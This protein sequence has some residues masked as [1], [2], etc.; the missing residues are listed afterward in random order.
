MKI[1]QLLLDENFEIKSNEVFGKIDAK[2]VFC[3]ADRF[4]LEKLGFLEKI[5]SIY[6]NANVVSCS[7]S[8]NIIDIE[9]IENH[10]VVTAIEFEKS[11]CKLSIINNLDI[12]SSY[13]VGKNLASQ[14]DT[15]NLK[16]VLILSDGQHING[17]NLIK[18]FNDVLPQ[19][20]ST[21]GGLAGDG[22]RFEKTLVGLNNNIAQGNIVAIAFYGENLEIKHSSQGGWDPFGPK[23]KVTKA[24]DNILYELDGKNALELYEIYLGDKAKDLPASGLLFPLSVT[25]DNNTLVRTILNIDND[26][27]SMIFAG[28]IPV[29]AT[30]Q[31]MRSNFDNL[32]DGAANA[33]NNVF[34]QNEKNPDLLFLVSCVGRKLVLG[35]RIEEELE[36]IK[37]IFGENSVLTGFYSYGEICPIMENSYSELHNQTM[38]IT[39]ISEL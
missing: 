26:N 29:G 27:Q 39:S 38:T 30:A 18:A 7:T 2:L 16:Y 17:S 35:G 20:V 10:Y 25:V 14:I 6:P 31:F 1:E 37:E 11:N 4:L 21:S 9:I 34:S 13:Q 23:R 5:K 28:D 3:F 15:N 24:V 12:H 33:G 32:I 22:A 36:V 19:N 8:G